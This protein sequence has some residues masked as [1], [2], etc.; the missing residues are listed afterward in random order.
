MVLQ[1]R[2]YIEDYSPPVGT[3]TE[4]PGH[5]V[6]ESSWPSPHIHTRCLHL[7][8]NGSLL[9]QAGPDA[10]VEICSPCSTGRAAGECMG[11]GESSH[12]T[13]KHGLLDCSL[14]SVIR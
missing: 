5:W 2:A 4:T 14:D 6:A 11:C 9:E 10:E 12:L 3:R 1:V 8:A 7:H 13:D